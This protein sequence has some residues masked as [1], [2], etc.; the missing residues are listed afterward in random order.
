M[1][2]DRG[3]GVAALLSLAVLSCGEVSRNR[4]EAEGTPVG[5]SA[6]SGAGGAG[7]GTAASSTGE[8]GLSGGSEAGGASTAPNCLYPSVV[9]APLA[10]GQSDVPDYTTS[11]AFPVNVP[12]ESWGKLAA[13]F[14]VN[15]D[16]V[17]DLIY[18]DR[19]AERFRLLLS[20][21]PP[22]VFAWSESEC[23]AVA[24]LPAGRLFLRDLDADD[25]PDFII[26]TRRGVVAYLN[27][28]DGL[29]KVLEFIMPGVTDHVELINLDAVDLD[30]DGR[31]DL[32]ASYDRLQDT[33]TFD[34]GMLSFF[35]RSRGH[36]TP[37]PQPMTTFANGSSEGRRMFGHLAAG[38]FRPGAA[39]VVFPATENGEMAL[40]ETSF[41]QLDEAKRILISA[42]PET[43]HQVLRLTGTGRLDYLAV[44]GQQSLHVMD[45]QSRAPNELYQVP[46]VYAGGPSHEL[47]G[48]PASPRYYFVDID[49][50]GDQDFIERA[51]ENP[52]ELA[53][54]VNLHDESFGPPQILSVGTAGYAEAPFI[55]VGPNIGIIDERWS[56]SGYA[57]PAVFTVYS[58]KLSSK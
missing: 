20:G 6:G 58:S 49:R 44:V 18:F 8:G 4:G 47:G 19:P 39:S 26:G 54:H 34:T 9:R 7:A 3:K 53:L 48:G 30:S 10:G 24:S 22:D 32:V 27:H 21:P 56:D 38:S 45:L 57:S 15:A 1:R 23:E 33:S 42:P 14:D 29:E 31:V 37:G 55:D 11:A 5:G 50:D 25:V 51:F 16:W 46:L 12:P 43:I 35:Q 28:A 52:D 13:T 36:L 40:F 2:V 41:S 17:S